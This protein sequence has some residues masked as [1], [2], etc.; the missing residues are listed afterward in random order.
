MC[1]HIH[2]QA[3]PSKETQNKTPRAAGRRFTQLPRSALPSGG[4]AGAV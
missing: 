1:R 3:K 2:I 4:V